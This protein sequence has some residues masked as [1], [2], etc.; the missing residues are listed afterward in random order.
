MLNLN[1]Y[2]YDWLAWLF[3]LLIAV[4]V[5]WQSATSLVEQ[6]V[7]SGGALQNAAAFPQAIAWGMIFLSILNLVR[8]IKGHITNETPITTT[9]TTSLAITSTILFFIY[10]M[11][12]EIIGYYIGTPIL[13]TLLLR[14]LGVKWINSLLVAV[15]M[16]LVVAS[17]FEGLL[18]VV[19]PLGFTKLTLFG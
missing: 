7:A 10:L 15:L 4:L 2:T 17:I 19:L 13:L 8:I 3:F 14:I 9:K 12:L 11:M 16:T 1:K 6:G 18:N 5:L